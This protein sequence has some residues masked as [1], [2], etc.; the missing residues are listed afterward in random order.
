[1][2]LLSKGCLLYDASHRV[3]ELMF[4]LYETLHQIYCTHLCTFKTVVMSAVC[5][6]ENAILVVESTISPD[7]RVT[8]SCK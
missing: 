6:G 3:T 1:M 7:R 4:R 8:D 2:S 5:V